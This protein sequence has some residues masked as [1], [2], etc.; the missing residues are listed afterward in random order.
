MPTN[1][2]LAH[3]YEKHKSKLIF[4]CFA[5]P[6]FDGVRAIWDGVSFIS[7]NGKPLIVP[8][9][10]KKMKE[11]DIPYTLDGEIYIHGE[12]FDSI[13]GAVRKKSNF[14][15]MDDRLQYVAFDII[16][17]D[18]ILRDRI[19]KLN[20]IHA[21]NINITS[22]PT[23]FLII[24][25]PKQINTQVSLDLYFKEAIEAK[26][27][28]AIYRNI[29]SKYKLKRSFNLL[30]R[31]RFFAITGILTDV[32][33]GTKRLIGTLGAIKVKLPSGAIVKVGTGFSD[34]DRH[35]IWKEY[36]RTV[37]LGEKVTI[38]YQELTKAGVPRFPV[39]IKLG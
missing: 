25:M 13:S 19:E 26:F 23:D 34:E 16:E 9:L 24:A 17:Q 1:V 14:S 22:Q 38:K 36:E 20:W 3:E 37:I 33:E 28:G 6:K 5:Q 35:F 7:R 21:V 11:L 4:P 32:I 12:S 39:F 15:K 18:V 30:K 31:K 27:E 29:D 2:M 10:T 8:S